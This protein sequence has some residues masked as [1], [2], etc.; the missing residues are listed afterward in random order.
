[1]GKQS[2]PLDGDLQR[3]YRGRAWRDEEPNRRLLLDTNV[4][5]KAVL[6]ASLTRSAVEE[7][8]RLTEM[9]ELL[10]TAGATV[11]H[12]VVQRRERPD[13]RL[14]LGKGRLEELSEWVKD[15]G[16]YNH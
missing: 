4:E 8:D 10:R 2:A 16:R 3:T 6:I 1:M 13:P 7:A 12:R 5:E 11:V 9:G 14:Y 15:F